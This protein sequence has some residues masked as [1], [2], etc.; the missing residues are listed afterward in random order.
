MNSIKIGYF[1][2]GIWAHKA[3]DLL[4]DNPNI[5]IS[6]ICSRYENPDKVLKL[7]AKEIGIKF[8]NDPNINSD[9]FLKSISNHECDLYISMSFDQIFKNKILSLPKLG[10]INCH[11]G[12]LPFYRGRNILNWVLI[13][14]EKEFGIT[15]HYVD[16]GI[17]TGDI[18]IQELF[19]INDNDTYSS[20]LKVAHEKCGLLLLKAVELIRKN[21]VKKVPQKNIMRYGMYCSRRIA[22]DEFINWDQSSREIF[23]FIRALSYPG[24][25]ATTF[26]NKLPVK[27]ISVNE[28]KEAPTYKGFPGT[29]LYKNDHYLL[30]KTKDTYIKVIKWDTKAKI[31]VGDRFL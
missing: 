8:I 19:P 20:L 27:I 15:V 26:V 10:I 7:K 18:I 6:F 14:D 25:C 17:D 5:S 16:E 30:V 11:A 3:L 22:G 12:K 23:N 13:N 2:D 4:I 21:K 9:E 1:G 29:I 31:K 24:P 28:L